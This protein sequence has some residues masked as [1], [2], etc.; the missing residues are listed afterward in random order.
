MIL[1]LVATRESSFGKDLAPYRIGKHSN[2]QIGQ[3]CRK[4]KY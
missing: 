3:K 2:P 4:K 1:K